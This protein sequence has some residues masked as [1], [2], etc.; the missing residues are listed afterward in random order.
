MACS[1][2]FLFPLSCRKSYWF[3]STLYV[4]SVPSALC[5]LQIAFGP[6][7]TYDTRSDNLEFIRSHI[8]GTNVSFRVVVF[9][10]VYM[11]IPW[12]PP[13]LVWLGQNVYYCKTNVYIV[14]NPNLWSFTA[15]GSSA[16]MQS[17]FF[18][19]INS[20]K[21]VHFMTVFFFCHICWNAITLDKFLFVC[22]YSILFQLLVRST[23]CYSNWTRSH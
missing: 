4:C 22:K 12:F 3:T 16:I 19:L 18:I 7:G 15:F 1:S 10:F 20:C 8:V 11:N 21:T 2:S 17:N 6:Y 23:S 14:W 13:Q 5:I 9:S